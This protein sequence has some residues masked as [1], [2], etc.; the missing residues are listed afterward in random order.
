MYFIAVTPFFFLMS[1]TKLSHNVIIIVTVI[2]THWRGT[3]S[4]STLESTPPTVNGVLNVCAG[5][6]ISLTCGHNN[7]LTGNTHWTASPPVN[8]IT[9]VSHIGANP[10]SPPPCGHSCFKRLLH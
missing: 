2:I 9:D 10:P 1:G 5:Q 6:Q 4:V 8:C 3:S 7:I